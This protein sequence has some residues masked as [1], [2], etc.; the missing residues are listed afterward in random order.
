MKKKD[1]V[2]HVRCIIK[3]EPAQIIQELKRRGT[4]TSVKEAIVLGLYAY[5]DTILQLDLK[6]LEIEKS[7]NP[8][9]YATKENIAP[10]NQ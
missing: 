4:V 9:N 2:V 6:R 10:E 8:D 3:G 1:D 7:R 5:Y